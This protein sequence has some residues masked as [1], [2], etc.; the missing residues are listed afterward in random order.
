VHFGPLEI[1]AVLL[2]ALLIF[3]P[4]QIPSLARSFGQAITEFKKGIKGVQD[5]ATDTVKDSEKSE[6]SGTDS[7]SGHDSSE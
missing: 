3:G 2:V 7:G 4:K 1:G 5:D 6:H